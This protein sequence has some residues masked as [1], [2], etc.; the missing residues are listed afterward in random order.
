MEHPN[1]AEGELVKSA[2]SALKT[3]C[4][5][6]LLVTLTTGIVHDFI[7]LM[8][9][10]EDRLFWRMVVVLYGMALIIAMTFSRVKE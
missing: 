10:R 8:P 9:R 5:V 1:R 4:T 2:W 6:T 7:R 3:A